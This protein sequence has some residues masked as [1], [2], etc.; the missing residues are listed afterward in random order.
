MS[1]SLQPHGWQD[2]RLPCPSLPSGVCLNSYHW[3]SDAI[4]LSHP[5]LSP[6]LLVLSL[7]QH[8]G[9]SQWV[10]SSHQVAKVLK[11]QLQHQSF[12]RIF[13]VDFLSDW[14]VWS[15]C[16]LRDSP[17]SPPASQFESINSLALSLLYGTTLTSIHDT[18]KTTALT[19]GTFVGI[20][21]TLSFNVLSRFV[22]AFLPRSKCLLIS[23]LQSLSAVILEPKKIKSV[24][25][26]TFPHLFAMK[27]WYWLP[28]C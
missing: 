17:E 28:W 14:L 11:L 1:N 27:W 18:G 2:A 20:L 22:I 15:P 12:Q 25:V 24:T 21:I 5:L 23:W 9:F 7:S 26:S 19:I 16:S 13:R 3:V 6:S 4:Q 10:G 8:Q